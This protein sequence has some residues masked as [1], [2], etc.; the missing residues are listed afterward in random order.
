MDNQEKNDL[1][2]QEIMTDKRIG[3]KK[4]KF[5]ENL[6][7]KITQSAGKYTGEKGKHFTSY[8]LALPDFFMLL[9]RLAIDKRVTA[10][11]KAFIGAI[12]AYLI[13]PLDFIPDF[14]PVIGFAD[15]LVLVVFGLNLIL[16]EL[17]K[18]ILLENWSGEENVLELLAKIA[19]TAEKFLDKNILSKIKKWIHRNYKHNG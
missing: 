1:I 17:D 7:K 3:N 9:C 2:E 12:I 8:L 16:N 18:S 10:S 11:Q 15:D 13:L 4:L 5:Y 14:I 6:R 19:L